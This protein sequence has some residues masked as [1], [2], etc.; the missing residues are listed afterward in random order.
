MFAAPWQALLN[1]LLIL[2]ILATPIL[3]GAIGFLCGVLAGSVVL[4]PVCWW[5]GR[6]NGAPFHVG[7]QVR[8]L[9]GPYR[10]E[11]RVVYAV[12]DERGEV[13]LDFGPQAKE[14]FAD[15]YSYLEICRDGKTLKAKDW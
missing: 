4:P 10:D 1:P 12:W 14:E 15:V 9:L 13:R 3:A 5:R 7:D 8:V 6:V 11:V 2:I